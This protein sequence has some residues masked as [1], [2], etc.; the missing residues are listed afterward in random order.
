M[1][2]FAEAAASYRQALRIQPDYI[3]AIFDLAATLQELGADDEAIAHYERALALDPRHVAAYNN[4]GN[5]LR[6][7]NRWPEA[8]RCFS[9]CGWRLAPND[10][11]VHCN[12][13][14]LLK[15]QGA[16]RRGGK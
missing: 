14:V 6:G 16:A 15:D 2:R 11:G 1:G 5:L 8:E 9:P 3:A 13:G 10:A 12:L 4:L 7:R